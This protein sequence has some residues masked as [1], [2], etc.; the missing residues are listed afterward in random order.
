[1]L[2]STMVVGASALSCLLASPAAAAGLAPGDPADR[3]V[4]TA[5]AI[6][7]SQPTDIAVLPDGRAI[8]PQ[9]T[10]NLAVRLPDGTLLKTAG[11]PPG[12]VSTST[13]EQ[14]IL[15]LAA[16]PAFAS[17]HAFYFYV[18][19]G[20]DVNNR[21]KVQ[22]GYL[23]AGNA[24]TF[25]SGYVIDT[26]LEGP[27]NH[28][29]G[30]IVIHK[31]QLY[32]AVGDAGHYFD[33]PRNKIATCL[34]KP[35]GK[36]LRV[37]LDGQVPADNPL[38]GLTQ[39]SGCDT[40]D[41]PLT[42]D[43]AP[44]TRIFAW[45]LR[46]PFRFWIDPKTDLLWVGDVGNDAREE[47]SVGTKGTHFG[48]PF[49]EGNLA[50]NQTWNVGC[51]GV[52]P[53]RPCTAPVLDYEHTVGNCVIGGLIPEGCGWPAAYTSRYFYGDHGRDEVYT[54][55][56]TADR[57]GVVAGSRALFASF[58]GGMSALR[59]GPDGAL[60]VAVEGEGAVYRIQ[61]KDR[62]TICAADSDG[63]ADD[64]GSDDAAAPGTDAGA[65]DVASSP[66]TAAPADAA[67]P[68]DAP[69]PADAGAPADGPGAP[70]DAPAA[71]A[72]DAAASAM[73][74]VRNDVAGGADAARPADAAG[75]GGSTGTGGMSATGGSSGAG[76]TSA[77]GG[78]SG[79][80]GRGGAGGA[81]TGGSSGAGGVPPPLKKHEEDGC[82]CRLG[83]QSRGGAV[84]P[85]AIVI[86]AL[87]RRRR[88]RAR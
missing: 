17:S 56:V 74:A 79:T 52:V 29:G 3:F 70:R 15:G 47:I 13:S 38:M 14:G 34:N 11:R 63:G 2:A 49:M 26:G 71:D 72:A 28:N 33:P 10:G 66:D 1:L 21:H 86:A 77:T 48:W 43:R 42:N 60:Y 65:S 41:A 78:S 16:D 75:A 59:M 18:S 57:H 88:R 23:D 44:D 68:V 45:G 7:L 36:I 54:L 8:I 64:G 84:A 40:Y 69:P 83:G 5:Y 67:L 25:D 85:L 87:V 76:G 32:V 39:V 24:F 6:G 51:T 58:S 50:Y 73:D 19:I 12:S 20:T 82:G 37:N 22:R 61:P 80:G 35:N 81:G 4:M 53:S 46:N 55:D 27:D 31:G 30:G 9:R 62:P